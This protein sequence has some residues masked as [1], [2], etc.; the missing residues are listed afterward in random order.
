MAQLTA[1]TTIDGQ[2]AWH[3]GN[4]GN[5]IYRGN[6]G[7]GNPLYLTKYE[8]S[9]HYVGINTIT[10]QISTRMAENAVYEVVYGTNVTGGNNIDIFLYPNN[11]TYGNVIRTRYW[12][13]PGVQQ[14]DNTFGYFWFDHYAGGAGA[15]PK[16]KIL[17]FNVRAEK[18]VMYHG[19]DTASVCIG[20]GDWNDTGTVWDQVG[21]LSIYSGN[22][23]RLYA[24][25]R[26]IG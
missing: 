22:A 20:G 19:G 23:G 18:R 2:E 7:A 12:C 17:I 4:W 24:T 8:E 3:D 13:S 21:T 15:W 10:L 26:R 9:H 5:A 6:P 1:G 25:V 16:G 11:T 14:R